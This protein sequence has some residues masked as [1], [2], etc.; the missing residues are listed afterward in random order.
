MLSKIKN[1][2]LWPWH[3]YKERQTRKKRLKALRDQDPFIYE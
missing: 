1:F 3:K 2:I